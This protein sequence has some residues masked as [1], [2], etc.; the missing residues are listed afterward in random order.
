M[1]IEHNAQGHKWLNTFYDIRHKWSTAFNNDTFHYGIKSTSQSESANM[2][3]MD[4]VIKP[5]HCLSLLR[6]LRKL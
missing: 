3:L 6:V 1:T 5:L 4:L 2:F